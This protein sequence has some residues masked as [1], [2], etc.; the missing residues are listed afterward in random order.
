[1]DDIETSTVATVYYAS[2]GYISGKE[3]R[4][5]RPI[6]AKAKAAQAVRPKESQ[7]R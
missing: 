1:M 7:E 5:A 4:V 2:T 3:K 6:N